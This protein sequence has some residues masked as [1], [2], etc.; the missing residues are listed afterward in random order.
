MRL[1]VQE[2]DYVVDDELV[3]VCQYKGLTSER[4][5][6]DHLAL[7]MADSSLDDSYDELR[8]LVVELIFRV[9]KV[10]EEALHSLPQLL[11]GTLRAAADALGILE[12]VRP[13]SPAGGLLLSHRIQAEPCQV[14]RAQSCP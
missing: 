11:A 6:V 5:A 10:S 14:Q 12:D 2:A 8:A 1:L 4:C 13:V 7:L 9:F 3:I